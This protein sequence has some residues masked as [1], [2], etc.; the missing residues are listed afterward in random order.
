MTHTRVSFEDQEIFKAL[1]TCKRIMD[2]QEVP[3]PRYAWIHPE[4]YEELRRIIHTDKVNIEGCNMTERTVKDVNK[5]IGAV[6]KQVEDRT[7]VAGGRYNRNVVSFHVEGKEVPD[8]L[9]FEAWNKAIQDFEDGKHKGEVVV[10]VQSVGS[11]RGVHLGPDLLERIIDVRYNIINNE[12]KELARLRRE[13][14]TIREVAQK[15]EDKHYGF[16]R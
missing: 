13:R 11:D 7:F 9:G 8:E 12:Q 2:E 15:E 14:K 3:Q 5:D 6:E 16:Q 1:E 4:T 10:T